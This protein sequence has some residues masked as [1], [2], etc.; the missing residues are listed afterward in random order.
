MSMETR[1]TEYTAGQLVQELIERGALRIYGNT[2]Y[3][4]SIVRRKYEG[5]PG[6]FEKIA[7]AQNVQAMTEFAVANKLFAMRTEKPHDPDAPP[8]D[9]L[10]IIEMVTLD[11][12]YDMD[13][14]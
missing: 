10:Y 12:N 6:A 5:E 1:L 7:H 2:Q 3:V 4:P 13:N 9:E 14:G 8:G 11:P